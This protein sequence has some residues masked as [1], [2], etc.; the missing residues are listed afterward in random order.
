MSDQ[1]R[2]K[3][4]QVWKD[5]MGRLNKVQGVSNY[6][7]CIQG[8]SN[9]YDTK[10]K[11]IFTHNLDGKYPH[12]LN[13]AYDLVELMYDPT[14]YKTHLFN[15]IQQIKQQLQELKELLKDYP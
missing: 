6:D 14:E 11:D 13:G 10:D 15:K 7:L 12:K 2:F 9:T 4:G 3:V 8:C 1:T 5:R